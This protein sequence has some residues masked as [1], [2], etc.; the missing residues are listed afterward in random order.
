MSKNLKQLRKLWEASSSVVAQY[1][2]DS[3]NFVVSANKVGDKYFV[4][5]YFK[6]MSGDWMASVD[7]SNG[8]ADDA[9]KAFAHAVTLAY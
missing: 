5:R 7:L 1:E 4:F 3:M 8:S 9:L 6:G 2:Q